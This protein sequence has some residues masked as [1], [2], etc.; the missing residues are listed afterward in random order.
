M[1]G[2]KD[3]GVEVGRSFHSPTMGAHG[4]QVFRVPAWSVE[5]SR[6]FFL[7]GQHL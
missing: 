5:G 3:V 7:P 6:G 1:K 4:L 2:V